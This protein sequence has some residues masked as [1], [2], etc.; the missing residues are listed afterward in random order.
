ML[1]LIDRRLEAIEARQLPPES[2]WAG[3]LEQ[4]SEDELRQLVDILGRNEVTDEDFE[5]M[6]SVKR[7]Y[8]CPNGKD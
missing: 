2:E 7:K 3:I 8:G 5:F 4:C 6:L 1:K